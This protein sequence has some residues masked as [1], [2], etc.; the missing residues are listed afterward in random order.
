MTRGAKKS[1][2]SLALLIEK[3]SLKSGIE[4]YRKKYPYND[5]I[6]PLKSLTDFEQAE[7]QSNPVLLKSKSWSESKQIIIDAV[8]NYLKN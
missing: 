6:I 3:Y 7:E 5:D 8:K 2:F 4:W 1:F